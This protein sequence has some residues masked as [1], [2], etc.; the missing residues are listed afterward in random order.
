M[1][2]ILERSSRS[3]S[4]RYKVWQLE[5]KRFAAS[6]AHRFQKAISSF[7]PWSVHQSRG[8]RKKDQLNLNIMQIAI[9]REVLGAWEHQCCRRASAYCFMHI[10]YIYTI[11]YYYRIVTPLQPEDLVCASGNIQSAPYDK[12]P[13]ERMER[14]I[15]IVPVSSTSWREK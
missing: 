11:L 15:F 12:W 6:D 10:L 9:R 2:E 5:F 7:L 14:W 8:T 13:S 3:S 1:K 4:V